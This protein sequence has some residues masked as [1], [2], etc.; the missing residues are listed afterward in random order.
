MI[1]LREYLYAANHSPFARWFDELDA[2]A[3]IRVGIALGRMEMGNLSNA[4]SLGDG[5]SEYRID[6]GPGCRIYFGRDGATVLILLGGGT[7]KRQQRDIDAAKIN[8]A[9]YKRKRISGAPSWR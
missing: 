7:K 2:Q 1:E 4:K 6:F 3:A 9:D 5:V 8:W